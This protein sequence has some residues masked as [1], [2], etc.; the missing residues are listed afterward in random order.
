MSAR[1]VAVYTLGDQAEF[2]GYAIQKNCEDPRVH[3]LTSVN[4]WT[5]DETDDLRAQLARL[6][7]QSEVLKFWPDYRDPE[8]LAI[9]ANPNFMPI[10][11]EDADVVDEAKSIIV[12]LEEPREGLPYGRMDEDNSVIVTKTEKAPTPASQ[13]A[14]TKGAQEIVA[15]R[16][17]ARA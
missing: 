8:V 15:R 6:N 17:S 10:Q 3:K 4:L 14:R 11:Y 13:Q 2:V 5:D 16:R 9:L 1:A 7:D 12:W